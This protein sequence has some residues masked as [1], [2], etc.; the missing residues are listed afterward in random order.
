VTVKSA[1]IVIFLLE[2]TIEIIKQNVY[3]SYARRRIDAEHT[4][5]MFN[6]LLFRVME[7]HRI[8][9]VTATPT[10]EGA[11]LSGLSGNAE[12]QHGRDDVRSNNK[13]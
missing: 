10:E 3:N 9:E 5:I 11:N 13:R 12:S 7:I 2:N 4:M 8:C 1:Y 6:T